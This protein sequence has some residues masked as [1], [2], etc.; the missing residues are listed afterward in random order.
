MNL[1][2]FIWTSPAQKSE[3]V[4]HV[5]LK[6][7][8]LWLFFLSETKNFLNDP[9]SIKQTILTLMNSGDLCVYD[10]P[11]PVTVGVSWLK[12]S[13]K[14]KCN[15]TWMS[16]VVNYQN[17]QKSLEYF[18]QTTWHSYWVVNCL[19]HLISGRRLPRFYLLCRVELVG[20]WSAFQKKMPTGPSI[21]WTSL[22]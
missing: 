12:N 21:F 2:T 8:L 13:G 22:A 1:L 18:G 17:T 15:H 6:N 10:C 14:C 11:H 7:V 9:R 4:L 16:D 3:W 19:Q 20:A 5:L